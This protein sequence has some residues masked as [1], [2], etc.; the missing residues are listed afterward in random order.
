[1]NEKYVDGSVGAMLRMIVRG[2]CLSLR[3]NTMMSWKYDDERCVLGDVQPA[4]HVLLYCNLYMDVRRRW[5]ETM[6]AEH[7]FIK[8]L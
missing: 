1:M 8:R 6:D 5:K 4:E 2:G 7:T 3:G